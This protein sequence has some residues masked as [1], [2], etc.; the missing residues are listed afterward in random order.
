MDEWDDCVHAYSPAF[1]AARAESCQK[2]RE[3]GDLCENRITMSLA[4]NL[5]MRN[6]RWVT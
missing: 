1:E 5:I 6:Q 2:V 4:A 3:L